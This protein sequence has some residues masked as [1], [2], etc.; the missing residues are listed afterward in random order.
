VL[1]AIRLSVK[2]TR[3]LATTNT[4]R[5]GATHLGFCVW[6][7]FPIIA[8]FTLFGFDYPARIAK[9][10]SGTGGRVNCAAQFAGSW[11]YVWTFSHTYHLD[12]H[13]IPNCSKVQL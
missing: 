5:F 7:L 11:L 1:V 10:L 4:A 6:E 3:E 8:R 13:Y 9:T 2:M 12:Y